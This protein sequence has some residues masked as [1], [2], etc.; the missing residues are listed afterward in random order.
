M[1]SKISCE[2][3]GFVL[4]LLGECINPWLPHHR[5]RWREKIPLIIKQVNERDWGQSDG[6]PCE[7]GRAVF[8]DPL[9]PA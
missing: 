1:R 4:M 3:S 9:Y 5:F 6:A 2:R 7:F 8:V